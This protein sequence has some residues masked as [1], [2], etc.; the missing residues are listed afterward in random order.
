MRTLFFLLL[1]APLFA[2]DNDAQL[3]QRESLRF[4]ATEQQTSNALN[5]TDV[6]HHRC[7]WTV[8]PALRY[9]QGK[10]TTTVRITEPAGATQLEFD[11]NDALQ[12]TAVLQ[13]GQALAYQHSGDLLRISLA[14]ALSH[15]QTTAV[16]IY[17]HGIPP[18]NGFGAFEQR[19]HAGSSIVW[20]LSE[21]YGARDWWPCKQSLQDKIDSMDIFIHSPDSFSAA[22]NGILIAETSQNGQKT[23]HWR[24]RYPI[25]PYLVCFAVTNYVRY[26]D[27]VPAGSDSIEV[28]NYVYPESEAAARGQTAQIIEQMQL[29]NSLFGMYPF[30]NE[31]YG[32]AQFSWGGGMEHQTMT[33]MGGWNYELMAHELAHHWFGDKITCGSWSDI[34]LNEGFATYLS[35]L[36]YERLRPQYWMPFKNGRIATVTLSP[37]GSVHCPDTSDV[38]RVFDGR[39]SYAKGAMV[40]HGLRWVLGDSAFFAGVHNYLH[41]PALAYRHARTADLKRHLEAS[42]NRDLT[43]FFNDWY[44]GEGYPMY[45]LQ[46]TR[47]SNNEVLIEIEQTSSHPSVSFYEMP[48]ALEL[49]GEGK[50]TMVVVQ[51]QFSGQSFSLA[52]DFRADTLLF[53]PERWI[54]QKNPLITAVEKMSETPMKAHFVPNPSTGFITIK[55]EKPIRLTIGDATGRIWLDIPNV[56][57][58]QEIDI[59]ALPAG[60][61]WVHFRTKT[62]MK[63]EKLVKQ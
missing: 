36:C 62:G 10:V 28:L 34:W 23:T 56:E 61:Y 59:Q 35:G 54:I 33:F 21:P 50:D 55:T 18:Q 51:H 49:R 44:F 40:L 13:N 27:Y 12:V 4:I 63:A 5:N 52:L 48:I 16:E 15:G 25:A 11:L 3:A 24:H 20:T 46:W 45:S 30:A 47:A 42:G 19:T 26:S 41:D 17:Y 38:D 7:E 29:F 39:L 37:G 22:A 60:L 8:N 14:A 6:L 2:Q 57:N 58:L 1:S 9:I 31:K 43:E 53:D 32:H